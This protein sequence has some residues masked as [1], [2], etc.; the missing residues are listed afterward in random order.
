MGTCRMHKNPR[1]QRFEEIDL[2]LCCSIIQWLLKNLAFICAPSLWV[3]LM[4]ISF[5]GPSEILMISLCLRVSCASLPWQLALGKQGI[6]A[7]FS[8]P[9]IMLLGGAPQL[10]ARIA[11]PHPQIKVSFGNFCLICFLHWAYPGTSLFEL[12]FGWSQGSLANRCS[13]Y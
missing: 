9:P 2:R 8:W 1:E 4:S 13:N 5:G 12:A 6:L 7:D 11:K 3:I 10:W